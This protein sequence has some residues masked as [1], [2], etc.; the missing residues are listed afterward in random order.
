MLSGL[1]D[2]LNQLPPYQEL[3]Q[4]QATA[5]PTDPL[6][7]LPSAHAYLAAGLKQH[8][9]NGEASKALILLTA[10]TE[11]A[12]QLAEQLETWLPSVEEGGPPV[13]QFS[14][15]DALPYERISWSG[16]TRQ[17][18]ITA[19]AALQS[20]ATEQRPIVVA[21]VR[22]L[23]QKT[24]P[25]RELRLALRSI[26][27]GSIVRL[28][29]MTL[30]W[31]QTGYSHTDVVEEPGTFARRG[32]IVDIWPPNLARPIR[33][34]LFGD[35]VD[36]LRYFDP[37]TQRSE[38]NIS[39]AEI[40]PGSEALS[41]YGSAALE[42]LN[43]EGDN[44][45]AGE[46]LATGVEGASPLQDS[47]LLLAIRE[48]LR[49][50]VGLLAE[51]NSFHGI[52]WYLPY[53]YPQPASLLDYMDESTLLVLDD[54]AEIVQTMGE[55]EG[56]ATNL[57]E[58]LIRSGELPTDF[59]SSAFAPDELREKLAACHPIVLGDGADGVKSSDNSSPLAR[60]FAPGPRYGGRTK[61]IVRDLGKLQEEGNRVVLL[62]R[63]A[64]RVS[65]LFAEADVT[66]TV[67][68]ELSHKP[69][70]ASID[71][72]QHV[73][74]EGFIVRGLKSPESGSTTSLHFLTDTELFG[75]S[76][77]RARRKKQN[78]STVAPEIFFADVKE[79]EYVVHL[80]HGIGTYDGLVKMEVG[81]V[82][83]EYLQVSYAKEDKLYVP[84]HQA[85][86]LSRYVGAGDSGS[87]PVTRLGT[88]DWQ[89]VKARAKK[90]VADIADDL[91][92]LYAER[93]LVQGHI[94]SPDGPWQQELE[95]SFPFQ[96][97]DDQLS[98]IEAVKIDMESERP[99]DRLICGDVGYGKTEVAV[100]A[101]FKAIM[102]GRQVAILVP[103]TVL[104]QQHYRTFRDRLQNFPVNVEMLSRFRTPDVQRFEH[105][106]Y[107]RRAA[108]WRFTEGTA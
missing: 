25:S 31:V 28:D 52:E 63:Q 80:E 70:A 33:I 68:M 56:Q 8:S 53:F 48:Q 46:N 37:A 82:E 89:Q 90:A 5:A 76:K 92:K 10:R 39:S 30:N 26:K 19:L 66:A 60:S 42:R 73:M 74:G 84:V 7:V 44:L 96:E 65:S 54:E 16:Q 64:A 23:L 85:D 99:M 34:D 77:P 29:Q 4:Q 78:Q 95:A 102:D 88:A 79:G 83:R 62:T 49:R 41:K 36:S 87:P 35:E 59:I 18:R 106:Y 27:V 100:R 13:Y 43:I 6:S 50:E 57:R 71:I 14:A 3:L 75:W 98:A 101:A 93:E 86:R 72:L 67:S 108:L 21:S 103:T 94:Y 81:G 69:I 105:A 9:K 15:P 47:K 17:Q 1:L 32:G 40:G 45:Y 38:Q 24:L 97:T 2:L 11:V 61:P 104:A 107:R 91:L 55:L 58:E 22:A 51:G 12:Y 20:R